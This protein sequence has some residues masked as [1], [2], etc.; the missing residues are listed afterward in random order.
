M[1]ELIL[2]SRPAIR[3]CNS[4]K[5]VSRGK[6]YAS[7]AFIGGLPDVKRDYSAMDCASCYPFSPSLISFS[8]FRKFEFR[9]LLEVEEDADC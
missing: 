3:L 5:S 9:L 4:S 8:S 2:V 6:S 1:S 7:F